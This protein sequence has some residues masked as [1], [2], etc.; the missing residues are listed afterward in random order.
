MQHSESACM[1][2]FV[3]MHA[4]DGEESWVFTRT[5]LAVVLAAVYL[6]SYSDFLTGFH[7]PFWRLIDVTLV[8]KISGATQPLCS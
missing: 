2:L 1:R 7:E 4:L 5:D 6:I 3:P 8:W